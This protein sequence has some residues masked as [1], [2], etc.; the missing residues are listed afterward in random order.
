MDFSHYNRRTFYMGKLISFENL[1]GKMFFGTIDNYDEIDA[2]LYLFC[3]THSSN[4]PDGSILVEQLAPSIDLL[5]L[6]KAWLDKG[7]FTEKYNEFKE[8]YLQE[9]ESREEC[10]KAVQVVMDRIR[11]GKDIV[12]FDD[13]NLGKYCHLFILKDYFAKKGFRVEAINMKGLNNNPLSAIRW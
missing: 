7:I 2:H 13:C 5:Y 12:L 4:V 10:Q 11:E 9:L 6:K 8:Q 3:T 1:K